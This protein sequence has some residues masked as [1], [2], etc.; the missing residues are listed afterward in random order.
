MKSNRVQLRYVEVRDGTQ[1]VGVDMKRTEMTK[2]SARK[3]GY[4]ALSSAAVTVLTAAALSPWF[5]ALGAPV[6]AYLTYRW[7]AYRAKWGLRF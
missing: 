3:K 6:T 1:L 4:T 2:K 5:A 7:L